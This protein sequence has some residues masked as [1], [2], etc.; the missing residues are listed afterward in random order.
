MERACRAGATV[1]LAISIIAE[2]VVVFGVNIYEIEDDKV[3]DPGPGNTEN[4]P[5]FGG[6]AYMLTQARREWSP[7]ASW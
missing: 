4:V 5:D 1:G 2:Y 7:V 3:L 6:M